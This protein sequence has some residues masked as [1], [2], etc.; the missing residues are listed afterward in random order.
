MPEDPWTP[1]PRR[2]VQNG[3]AAG[4]R[5]LTR[6]TAGLSAAA[7]V[8]TGATAAAVIGTQTDTTASTS[9]S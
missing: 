5:R 1:V 8:A 4:L 7:L 6:L 9:V 3:R 2:G